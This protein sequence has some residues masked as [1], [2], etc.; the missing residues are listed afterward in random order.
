MTA[1]A[2]AA[3][4]SKAQADE[5][6]SQRDN[7]RQA[8]VHQNAP[9]SSQP[10]FVSGEASAAPAAPAPSTHARQSQT[11]VGSQSGAVGG[12]VSSSAETADNKISSNLQSMKPFHLAKTPSSRVVGAPGDKLL[13]LLGSNGLISVSSDNGT[14]WTQQSSGVTAELLAGS[15]PTEQVCWIVGSSGTILRTTD[16]GA[17]W[18]KQTS[19]LTSDLFSIRATDALHAQIWSTPDPQS[20]SVRSY[21][22]NDGGVTWTQ[23]PNP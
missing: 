15:A 11:R 16:G 20:H 21:Q 19:P 18:F 17:H 14:T 7:E 9:T 2:Q 23:V 13:W 3:D 6:S 5:F 1:D 4:Q 22:T 8:A 10:A 12:A